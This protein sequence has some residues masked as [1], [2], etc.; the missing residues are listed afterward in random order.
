[1]NYR[2]AFH[3]GNFADVFKHIC[4]IL[5]IE[6]LLAKEKPF[7]YIDTH[8]GIG[9]YDLTS[10]QAKKT[11]EFAAGIGTLMAIKGKK[12]TEIKHYL[13]IVKSMNKE[14]SLK[15][16]PGS[17]R[18]VRALLRPEDKMILT[19][20]HPADYQLLKEEFKYDPQVGVHLQN[21]YQGLKAFLPPTP[22]R[23]VVLIDPPY[24]DKNEF[25]EIIKSLQMALMRWQGIYLI[26][27]PVKNRIQIN[28][29]E[30]NLKKLSL[31]NL[32][33]CELNLFPD[34]A[35]FALNG[36]GMVIVNPPWKLQE[37]LNEVLP[38]LLNILDSENRGNYR[39]ESFT[40]KM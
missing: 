21:G 19:E 7:C 37:K 36:S 12:P 22:R 11:G 13:Q 32:L 10:I 6:S 23:G 31:K 27:Y 3:A 8:A 34:D 20:L 5:V 30:R 33:I 2:H 38:Q 17:P 25:D 18:I 14:N 28:Q 29:F 24:E 1:M 26:W 35:P 4:L 16:Y 40:S 9:K 15:Y 39:L